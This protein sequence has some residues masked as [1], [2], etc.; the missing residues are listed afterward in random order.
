MALSSK[1]L[2]MKAHMWG[3]LHT[4]NISYNR[5]YHCSAKIKRKP[6]RKRENYITVFLDLRFESN[7]IGGERS[8]SDSVS[9]DRK[10][11]IT[12]SDH[13]PI[14][15]ISFRSSP[16]LVTLLHCPRD[17][18][19]RISSSEV[20]FFNLFVIDITMIQVSIQ[21]NVILKFS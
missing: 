3:L 13:N 18:I 7:R 5:L 16:S 10:R 20:F 11:I 1:M 8:N 12:V 6:K 2:R 4:T 21:L 14:T 17:S 15:F 19:I 9:C